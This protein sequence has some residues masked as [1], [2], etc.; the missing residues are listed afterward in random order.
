MIES[1]L[2]FEVRRGSQSSILSLSEAAGAQTDCECSSLFLSYHAALNCQRR[3]GG[4]E[5]GRFTFSHKKAAQLF[6]IYIYI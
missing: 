4:R 1:I 3:E 5:G 6:R 2:L